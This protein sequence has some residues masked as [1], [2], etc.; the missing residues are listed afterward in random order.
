M[1]EDQKLKP[2][3]FCGM[4]QYVELLLEDGHFMVQCINCQICGPSYMRETAA[5]DAWNTRPIEDQLKQS[6]REQAGWRRPDVEEPATWGCPECGAED[7]PK[8]RVSCACG[9]RRPSS[10][11]MNLR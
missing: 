4:E 2:C 11:V 9:Y 8:Y 3:P 5:V 7:W 6:Q 1:S 10:Q